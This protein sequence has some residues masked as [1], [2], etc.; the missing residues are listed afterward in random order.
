MVVGKDGRSPINPHLLRFGAGQAAAWTTK[1]NGVNCRLC[2]VGRHESKSVHEQVWERN[3]P[4]L[5]DSSS[6]WIFN[7]PYRNFYPF[8]PVLCKIQGEAVSK[9]PHLE[10]RD[11]LCDPPCDPLRDPL[12]DPLCDPLCDPPCEQVVLSMLQ[13]VTERVTERMIERVIEQMIERS[14]A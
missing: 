11:P 6:G 2:P 1:L 10:L 8:R 5:S 3:I 9:L 12:R 13:F 4:I 7:E 14:L